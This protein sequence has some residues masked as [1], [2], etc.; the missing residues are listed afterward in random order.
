VGCKAVGTV[1]FRRDESV[2]QFE[3]P[4]DQVDFFCRHAVTTMHA[5]LKRLGTV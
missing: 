2:E 5:A 1:A 4:L 3:R